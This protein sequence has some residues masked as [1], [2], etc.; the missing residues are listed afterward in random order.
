MRDTTNITT[1]AAGLR[2]ISNLRTAITTEMVLMGTITT[3]VWTAM[4]T[5]TMGSALEILPN[6][7][8]TSK[9]I[10]LNVILQGS[11]MRMVEQF[12]IISTLPCTVNTTPTFLN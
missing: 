1:L 3:E 9:V 11:S 4:E 10:M 12:L 6:S 7:S 5:S 8:R 2:G